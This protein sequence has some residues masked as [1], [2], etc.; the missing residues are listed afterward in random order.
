MEAGV[1]PNVDCSSKRAAA[2]AVTP[3]FD[4]PTCTCRA[5]DVGEPAPGLI[6]CTIAVPAVAP[7]PVA[8]KLLPETKVVVSIVPLN[9]TCAPARKLLPLTEMVKSPTGT[10]VGRT[11]DNTGRLVRRFTYAGGL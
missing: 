4:A 11:A 3:L 6:T 9:T 5:F 2:L 1:G 10:G 7:V 8:L